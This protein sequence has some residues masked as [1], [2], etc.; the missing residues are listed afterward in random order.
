MRD[1]KYVCDKCKVQSDER[2]ALNIS[3]LAGDIDLCMECYTAFKE[4]V[5]AE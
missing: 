2:L 3:D 5:F 1:I 4:W